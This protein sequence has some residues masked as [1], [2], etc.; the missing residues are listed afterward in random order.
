[1]KRLKIIIP[2]L[3]LCIAVGAVIAYF[4]YGSTLIDIQAKN[5]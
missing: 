3:L 5:L 2:V 4:V 1:M